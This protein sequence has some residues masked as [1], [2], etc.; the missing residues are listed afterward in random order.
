MNIIYVCLLIAY[1]MGDELKQV[2]R[3]VHEKVG[4]RA[5]SDEDL[6][7]MV[8]ELGGAVEIDAL[9]PS[10]FL[11]SW[12]CVVYL[13]SEKYLVTDKKHVLGNHHQ[14]LCLVSAVL[15]LQL[16]AIPKSIPILA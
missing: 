4:T 16:N 5:P 1:N 11:S 13:L 7:A 15:I 14:K 10:P 12:R 6:D 9:L 3:N 2:S 8:D